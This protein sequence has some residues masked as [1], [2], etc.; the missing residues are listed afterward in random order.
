MKKKYFT[1]IVSSFLIIFFSYTAANKFLNLDDFKFNLIKTG[2]FKDDILPLVAYAAIGMELLCVA[3]LI[4]RRKLGMTI[5]LVM[6]ILFT[7]YIIY[8]QLSGRYEVCGCGGILNGLKYEYHLIINMI[9]IA[10][11]TL[12]KLEKNENTK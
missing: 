10:L 7:I 8:L 2:L 9:I 4:W 11:I 5:S 3:L 1:V 12:V 6:M